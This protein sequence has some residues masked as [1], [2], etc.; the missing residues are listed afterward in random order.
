[1]FTQQ[2]Q[3]SWS[4]VI[5]V[6]RCH[7]H[8]TALPVRFPGTPSSWRGCYGII[9]GNVIR[10]RYVTIEISAPH[11]AACVC[12]IR[13][14]P[15]QLGCWECDTVRGDVDTQRINVLS[16]SRRWSQPYHVS[17]SSTLQHRCAHWWREN[18]IWHQA[19]KS[20]QYV[21]TSVLLEIFACLYCNSTTYRFD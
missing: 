13:F 14:L 20:V 19:K 16:N 9:W 1:M 4:K 6:N 8:V 21:T 18:E 5:S 2:Q 17:L 10:L 11:T 7:Q 3:Q 15:L 12:S